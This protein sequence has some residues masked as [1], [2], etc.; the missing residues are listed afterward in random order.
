MHVPMRDSCRHL[1]HSSLWPLPTD[2]RGKTASWGER[3]TRASNPGAE[4]RMHGSVLQQAVSLTD[5]GW[6]SD[7]FHRSDLHLRRFQAR[8]S[9]TEATRCPFTA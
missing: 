2:Q 1:R 3:A 8:Q 4:K 6:R 5:H 7:L 9:G